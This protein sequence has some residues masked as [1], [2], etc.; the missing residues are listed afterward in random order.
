MPTEQLN[1][2]L[3]KQRSENSWVH[4]PNNQIDGLWD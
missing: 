1:E 2:K 3:R 4:F